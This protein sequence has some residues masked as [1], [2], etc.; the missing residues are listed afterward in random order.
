MIDEL[1]KVLKKSDKRI[2]I[3]T[4]DFPDPDAIASAFGL[5][6]FMENF[7]IS[8]Q[9]TYCGDIVIT[10]Y[11]IHYTKLYEKHTVSDGIDP[12]PDSNI[13]IELLSE[14]TTLNP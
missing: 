8:S 9:I 6:N 11:S 13:G 2:F 14:R 4:H 1:L 3:Q 5:Q 12:S 7:G 10:S